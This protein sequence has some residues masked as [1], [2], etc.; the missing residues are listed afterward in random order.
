M[1]ELCF[2][3]PVTTDYVTITIGNSSL[4][5][6]NNE[7]RTQNVSVMITDDLLFEQAESF[8]LSLTRTMDTPASVIITQAVTVVNIVDNDRTLFVIHVDV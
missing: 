6:F 8:S 3:P 7:R 1:I 5:Q 4:D 2:S